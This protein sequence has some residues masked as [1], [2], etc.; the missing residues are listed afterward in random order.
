MVIRIDEY[1]TIPVPV[2]IKKILEEAKG[3]EE[4]GKFLLELYIEA[5]KLKAKKAFQK[6]AKKLTEEELENIL[7]SSKEFREGFKLK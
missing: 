4:W 7:E 1:S 2:E 5:K 3:E 6:L